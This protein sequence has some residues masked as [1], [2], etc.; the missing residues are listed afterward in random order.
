M[1]DDIVSGLVSRAIEFVCLFTFTETKLLLT[2]L[3][4]IFVT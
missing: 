2:I 1:P 4:R 3:D